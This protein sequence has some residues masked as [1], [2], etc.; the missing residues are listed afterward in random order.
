[1]DF[2]ARAESQALERIFHQPTARV[3]VKKGILKDRILFGVRLEDFERHGWTKRDV[4]RW[5]K[6]DVLLAAAVMEH[7]TH[8]KVFCLNRRE[9]SQMSLFKRFLDRINSLLGRFSFQ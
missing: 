1:V 2:K 7:G 9:A 5:L 4:K 8:F 6:Q 3:R